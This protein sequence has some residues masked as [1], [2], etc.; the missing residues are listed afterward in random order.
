MSPTDQLFTDGAAYERLMGRWSRRAGD[1]FID[2]IEAPRD[3]RWLD[4]GCG[5]GVLT[6]QVIRR[7]SPAAVVGVDPSGEQL[8]FARGRGELS[9]VEFHA[10]DAQHLPFPDNSFDIAVMALVIHF[11]P[12]PAKAVAE[13]GRA[14]R[15]GGTAAAYVWDYKN[16]GSPTAPLAAAMRAIGLQSPAPPSPQ[17]TSLQALEELWRA[18]G[19]VQ[20]GMRAIDISVEFADFENF[21]QSLTMPVGPAGKA[22]A[23]MSPD[24]RAQLRSV[25]EQQVP[26]TADGRVIYKARASAVKGCKEA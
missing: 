25:L 3:L 5:T 17:A 23:A 19:F 21:W 26:L 20:V 18:A 13:M 16:A 12:D 7:C 6:E 24:G 11:V 1:V 15:P 4:I 22:I 8:A 10:G 9:K 14:L 2:W